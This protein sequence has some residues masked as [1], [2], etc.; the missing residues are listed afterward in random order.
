[1]VGRARETGLQSGACQGKQNAQEAFLAPRPVTLRAASQGCPI[2]PI[3]QM[4]K[5]RHREGLGGSCSVLVKHG[6]PEPD[7]LGSIPHCLAN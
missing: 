7:Y 2:G 6:A 5:S 3:S 4:R 1:M